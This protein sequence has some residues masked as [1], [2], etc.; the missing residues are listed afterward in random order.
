MKR[1]G[2]NKQTLFFCIRSSFILSFFESSRENSTIGLWEVTQRTQLWQKHLN[3]N[4]FQ[5][6]KQ[7]LSCGR[8][9]EVNHPSLDL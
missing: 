8:I 2:A 9:K 3:K 5:N 1:T 7:D 4:T 6:P